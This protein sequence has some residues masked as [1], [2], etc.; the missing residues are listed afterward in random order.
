MCD[1]FLE[2][3]EACYSSEWDALHQKRVES[4]AVE[5]EAL[6]QRHE[7]AIQSSMEQIAVIGFSSVMPQ[8]E[9]CDDFWEILK[10]G[11]RVCSDYPIHRFGQPTDSGK[12]TAQNLYSGGFIDRVE[13]FDPQF[14]GF[15]LE[16][17]IS[18]DPQQRIFLETVWKAIEDAGYKASTLAGSNTGVIVGA[19]DSGFRD[20]VRKN[21]FQKSKSLNHLNTPAMVANRISCFLGLHGPSEAIDAAG[22]SSLLAVH[23]GSELIKAGE[24]DMVIAGGVRVILNRP[25]QDNGHESRCFESEG[26][27]AVI[28]KGLTRAQNDGDHI[29]AV[30]KGSAVNHSGGEFLSMPAE[31]VL[32]D[33]FSTAYQAGRIDPATVSYIESHGGWQQENMIEELGAFK[34]VLEDFGGETGRN[35][36]GNS[37]CGVG[38]LVPNIG[39]LEGA[40]GIAGLIKVLLCFQKKTLPVS[41]GLGF[42]KG[43]MENGGSHFYAIVNSMP[44]DRSTGKD[45]E[46]IPRRAGITALG[47]GGTNVHLIAEEY[48]NAL[49]S[50]DVV[51]ESSEDSSHVIVLSARSEERLKECVGKLLGFLKNVGAGNGCHNDQIEITMNVTQLTGEMQKIASATLESDGNGYKGDSVEE[52]VK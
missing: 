46:K 2:S 30:I 35:G 22:S 41:S 48:E 23:R 51:V 24:C 18:I 43:F 5:F 19:S 11:K 42:L 4:E 9:E 34:S 7:L 10:N 39:Y 45:G 40:T 28:L 47:F 33:L 44:W 31:S 21:S 1:E 8:A 25:E 3:F 16:E 20:W 37:H 12:K 49:S 13:F 32:R 17:A 50:R 52:F 38:S 26:A 6:P 15:S 27:G 29:Y 14:F 36:N